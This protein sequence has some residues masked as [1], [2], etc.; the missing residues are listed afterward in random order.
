MKGIFELDDEDMSADYSS[1]GENNLMIVDA[2]NLSFR[3]KQQSLFDH[4]AP[5]MR[6]VNSLANSYGCNN[7]V[8]ASD[9][10][11]S[12]FRKYISNG[13]YKSNR[14]EIRR[15]QTEEEA[16]KFKKF[17]EGFERAVELV[18]SIYPVVKFKGVEADDIA[19]YIVKHYHEKF[20]NI[21]LISSDKDWDLLLK[22]NVHRFSYV[23]REEYTLDNFAKFH[24]GCETP[25]DYVSMKV[26]SGDSGDGVPGF[27]GVG[28]KRAYNLIREYGTAL[29][30]YDA[31][32]LAGRQKY[33]QAVNND[34]E[35]I[36][37]NYELM[38]LLSYCTEAINFTDSTNTQKI[39]KIMEEVLEND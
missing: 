26:F 5:Y 10:G 27:P 17:F 34:P 12:K 6:T 19:G 9:W 30:V 8:I 13:M 36:L 22:P 1:N 11:N 31:V 39:H 28:G 4:S 24:D 29:D 33:I 21:W 23:T 20:D 18:G 37:L 32:P 38:D 7:V 14:E 2:L 35:R 15:N 16:E 3:Y 25:E